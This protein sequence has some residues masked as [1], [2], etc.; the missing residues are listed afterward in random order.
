VPR[1]RTG[2]TRTTWMSLTVT[3]RNCPHSEPVGIRRPR[4]TVPA[5]IVALAVLLAVTACAASSAPPPRATTKG[6][7][8][9]VFILADDLSWNLVSERL[10]PHL[11]ALQRKG[12]TFDHFVVA[13]SLCCPSRAT[14][15]TGLF[16][17]DTKVT[18]NYAPNGGYQG[19]QKQHLDRRTWAVALRTAGYRT[20]MLGKYLNAY[21]DPVGS[22]DAVP[23]GWTDWHVSNTSGYQQFHFWQND[24]GTW[25]HYLGKRNYGTDVINAQA[26]DFIRASAKEPFAVEIATYAPHDPY[27]PAPRNAD[28]FPGLTEPRD[29]SFDSNV[30]AAPLWL[31]QRRALTPYQIEQSDKVYRKRAQ[32]MEAV[33]KLLADTEATLAA[34]GVLDRTYIVFASDNGYHVGQYRLLHGKQTAFDTDIRVP[35]VIA[36]PGVPAGRTVSQVVQN[37][38]FYPTFLELAGLRTDHPIAGHSLVALLHPDARVDDRR[39]R[40]IALIEHEGQARP[41]DPDFEQ[42]STNP[43][44]Y[45]AIRISAPH[46]AGFPGPV[47]AVYVEYEDRQHELEF[48]DIARD[49]YELHNVAAALTPQQH[50]ELHRLLVGLHDCHDAATCWEAGQPG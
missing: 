31:G 10:T 1:P 21:G 45:E 5:I 47:E 8:N 33:D 30:T 29:P 17:H 48:Y 20:A 43:T 14:I 42:G 35:L 46:V 28:D 34:E 16:P 32:S 49:P 6:R 15:F 19:F 25:H 36:G 11:A 23:P 50:A 7:P 3:T 38:D 2:R 37:T 39:W 24:N 4:R 44:T 41:G 9:V 18:T 12:E 26:Q 22:N 27:T 40:T 13:D